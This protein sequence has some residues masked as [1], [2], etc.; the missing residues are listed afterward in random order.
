VLVAGF[1]GHPLTD[2]L[3]PYVD[4]FTTGR[5]SHGI[6][7]WHGFSL[8][9]VTSLTALA[10]GGV[11]FWQRG[12][13]AR[14]QSTFPTAFE[15]EELYQKAMRGLDRLAVEVTARTQRGSLPV[16][17]GSILLV[18]VLLPGGALLVLANWPSEI[19]YADT[20]AQPM[21]GLFL[22]ASAAAGGAPIIGVTPRQGMSDPLPQAMVLT[23]IVITLGVT[24][25]LLAM[26]YR[27]FQLN[28]HDEV[29]DDVEDAAIRQLADADR[30][31]GSYDESVEGRPDEIGRGT[32]DEEGERVAE[33]T[34][35]VRDSGVSRPDPVEGQR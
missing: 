3:T 30:G 22:F 17:L 26:A 33:T 34:V 9:L 6:A 5:N 23:A 28:G 27:S 14:A 7:L 19:R 35:R 18:V 20:S 16:Y 11:L 13:I 24:A 31:S 25:Y 32:G 15:S 2:A 8:P 29:P 4:A 21:V 10:V 1:F 12:F